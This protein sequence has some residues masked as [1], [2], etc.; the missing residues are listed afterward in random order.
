M[1]NETRPKYTMTL[2]LNVL[3][4]LGLNLYS[5]AP[6]V[7][8]EVVANSYDADATK[9]NINFEHDKIIIIDDG[10]GMNVEEINNKYLY[11][12]Y[13]KRQNGESITPKYNRPVMGRKG[14]G[15]LS[16]F[17]IASEIQLHSAKDGV[18]SALKMTKD[19][20]TRQIKEND[21]KYYPEEIEPLEIQN[22]TTIIISNLKKDSF[23]VK[24]LKKRLARRFSVIDENNFKVLV[25][26]EPI[27]VSDRDYLQKVQFLWK[28]GEPKMLENI[29]YPNIANFS[30]IDNAISYTDSEG[31]KIEVNINGWIGTVKQPSQLDEDGVNNNKISIISRGKMAQDDVLDSFTEGGIYADYIVGEI[32][33]DFLDEDD[34]IDIA[35]SSRQQINEEDPR[36][37]ALQNK[38]YE[39]LKTIQSE[40]TELRNTRAVEEIFNQ[41]P[42][43]KK[44]YDELPTDSY[45]GYAGKIFKTIDRIHFD[46]DQSEEKRTI[47]RQS[48]LAFEQLK[49][50]DSL[51]QIDKISDGNQLELISVFS[52]LNE[53]E[54]ILYYDI[55]SGRV[56]VIRE[57]KEKIDKNELEKVIQDLIFDNIWLL[58]PSW[59]RATQASEHMETRIGTAFKEVTDKLTQEEKDA[60]ID[61]GYRTA[62]GK[63]IIIELKRF[64]PSYKIDPF[65]LASQVDK[66]YNALKKCLEAKGELNPH[67]ETIC[68]IGELKTGHNREKYDQQLAPFNGRI[69]PYDQLI[70]ESLNSYQEYLEKEKIV[71]KLK[72]LL[73]E[74]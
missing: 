42:P 13:Q 39:I 7:L 16:L 62:G 21:G 54:A 26:G 51:D 27:S 30:T 15:K 50:R 11:V 35:T 22:G 68:I 49:I 71:G 24:S 55:A 4:H 64:N 36:F 2:S 37:V 46:K 10:N 63:H 32:E 6:A 18:V 31:V 20:I 19:E 34:N 52:Q 43:V 1:D 44:W 69:Y 47:V 25:D 17:S 57:L 53:L 28:I 65:I 72:T 70:E 41:Y 9:V 58:N 45:R 56:K 60:R 23:Q 48:I 61:I 74:I 40:W 66:Y 14:I 67:I 8:S 5:N 33:A 59:E 3:N 29:S 38:V 12:G 73:D